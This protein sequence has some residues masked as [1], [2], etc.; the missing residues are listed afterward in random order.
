MA[1]AARKLIGTHDFASFAKPGHGKLSTA[2][3]ILTADVHA[4]GPRLV[5][6]VE[7]TGFLWNMVRIIA[8]TLVEVGLGRYGPEQIDTMLAAKDRRSGGPTAP[9]HGLYLQWIKT[10]DCDDDDDDEPNHD[11]VR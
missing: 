2:R 4:R 8:G 5:I 10:R 9:P 6:G 11:P 3:T 1:R 7:G